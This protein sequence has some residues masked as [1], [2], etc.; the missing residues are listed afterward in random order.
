[1]VSRFKKVNLSATGVSIGLDRLLYALIQ[2]N[3]IEVKNNSPI[4]I[5]VLD[6]K[7]I[8]NYYEIL[9]KLRNQNIRSEVYLGDA[10]LKSQLKYADKRSAPAV[11]LFGDDE[12]KNN[13]ITIKK[14]NINQEVSKNLSREEWKRSENTQ[15]TFDKENLIDEIK[16][17]IWE[18]FKNY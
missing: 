5:C 16:K 14:L 2:L 6:K 17:L 18:Y 8:S 13:T 12:F 9:S 7:Y 4:I 10:G 1:M 15:I 3:K 11:I